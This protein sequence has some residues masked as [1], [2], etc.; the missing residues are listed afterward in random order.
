MLDV[1]FLLSG[2]C[3]CVCKVFGVWVSGLGWIMFFV[4]ILLDFFNGNFVDGR[5]FGC[6]WEWDYGWGK[7]IFCDG[8]VNML[9]Y[10]VYCM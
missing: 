2:C 1:L 9:G 6:D 10:F 5:L 3:C 7:C 4:F 8:I